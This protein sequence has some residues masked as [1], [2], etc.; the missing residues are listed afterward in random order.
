[1]SFSILS[2]VWFV[3]WPGV[4]K[5]SPRGH[6]GVIKGSSRQW[7]ANQLWPNGPW[8]ILL[9]WLMKT[10][11]TRPQLNRLSEVYR[12]HRDFLQTL[13]GIQFVSNQAIFI[14]FLPRQIKYDSAKILWVMSD[15]LH[16]Q[17]Q[18]SF[19]AHMMQSVV[20][21]IRSYAAHPPTGGRAVGASWW[22]HSEQPDTW[23]RANEG[24]WGTTGLDS[25][26]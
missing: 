20:R 2:T 10:R 21:C 25:S 1:M 17:V 16:T 12:C 26:N 7:T 5:G 9:R 18:V 13:W 11:I 3:L 23:G 8:D 22:R 4:I 19:N 15:A 24:R 6:Q 14:T